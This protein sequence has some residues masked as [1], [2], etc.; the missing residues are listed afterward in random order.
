MAATGQASQGLSLFIGQPAPGTTTFLANSTSGPGTLTVLQGPFSNSVF[1][2]PSESTL[3]LG[4]MNTVFIFSPPA[5]GNYT[6]AGVPADFDIGIQNILNPAQTMVIPVVGAITKFTTVNSLAPPLGSNQLLYT[7]DSVGGS[8]VHGAYNGGTIPAIVDTFN[9]FGEEL[10][11]KVRIDQSPPLFGASPTGI[12]GTI[13][14]FST[15]PEPGA[16]ALLLAAG[17]GGSLFFVRTRRYSA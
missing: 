5:T 3:A 17:V 11:L 12:E 9:F 4:T 6:F 15:V 1:V 10:T 14:G 2:T 7:V 16:L 8:S 13:Q